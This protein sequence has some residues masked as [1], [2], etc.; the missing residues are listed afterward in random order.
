MSTNFF[1][2]Q[3]TKRFQKVRNYISNYLVYLQ[4]DSADSNK[5][6]EIVASVLTRRVTSQK[7]MIFRAY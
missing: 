3:E 7:P 5:L 4:Y 1:V 2:N 6:I